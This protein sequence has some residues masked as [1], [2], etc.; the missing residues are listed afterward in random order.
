MKRK[1]LFVLFAFAGS[2]FAGTDFQPYRATGAA[3]VEAF[4]PENDGT[5]WA[6]RQNGE[7]LYLAGDTFRAVPDQYPTV[8]TPYRKF[9]GDA[10]RGHFLLCRDSCNSL[11]YLCQLTEGR[12][13]PYTQT[14]AVEADSDEG[15]GNTY[16]ARDGRVVSWNTHRIALW[17]NDRWSLLPASVAHDEGLPVFLECDGHI[18][19]VC[20]MLLHVIGPDGKLTTHRPN[21]RDPTFNCVQ[22]LGPLAVRTV[23]GTSGPQAF[24]FLNGQPQPL[25]APFAE[26][27]EPI[28][29]LVRS[30][31]GTVW[32]KTGRA[33]YRL[34]PNNKILRLDLPTAN[35]MELVVIS[36]PT[37]AGARS[38]ADTDWNVF[39]TDGQ[40]GLARWGA[41]GIE[42]L[43][44]QYKMA[45]AVR[46]CDN[47]ADGTLWFLAGGVEANI[48]R[49]PPKTRPPEVFSTDQQACWQS[50][51][52]FPGS[53]LM[54]MNGALAFLSESGRTLKRWDGN[55][56]TEQPLPSE[57]T[58]GV[59][60]C[61]AWDDQGCVYLQHAYR[62]APV[63]SLTEMSSNGVSITSDAFKYEPQGKLESALV[64]AVGRGATAFHCPEWKVT[65]T[66][67]KKSGYWT[68]TTKWFVFTTVRRGAKSALKRRCN[69]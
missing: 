37:D 30:T 57:T 47:T 43:G 8:A 14:L 49:L 36:D 1:H 60:T 56:F 62:T 61:E 32:T 22:W 7:L 20:G 44:E 31:S 64:R 24:N 51:R 18:A 52:V 55:V 28:T 17:Q 48:F 40:P 21:W 63:E 39:F 5:G 11:K 13:R 27:R 41:D 9:Y 33:L 50:F 19:M 69:L 10:E 66:P 65:I 45:E 4:A 42:R 35:S 67:E 46:T 53:R 12:A 2:C 6:M 38:D 26:V 54:E 68:A 59:L 29:T 23:R 16:I 25:P 34:G 58:N 15:F 3:T